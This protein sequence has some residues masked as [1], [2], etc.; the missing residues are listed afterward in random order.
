[1]SS[2]DFPYRSEPFRVIFMKEKGE[3]CEF[4]FTSE[5]YEKYTIFNFIDDR[6]SLNSHSKH[7]AYTE[8][9]SSILWDN[10]KNDATKIV[11]IKD[12][13]YRASEYDRDMI[14]VYSS[15]NLHVLEYNKGNKKG[16]INGLIVDLIKL[17]QSPAGVDLFIENISSYILDEDVLN[18]KLNEI[19]P[20]YFKIVADGQHEEK[21][22]QL[23]KDFFDCYRGISK[24]NRL[25]KVSKFL[26]C[27]RVRGDGDKNVEELKKQIINDF[28]DDQLEKLLETNIE[29]DIKDF[30]REETVDKY[31]RF[32]ADIREVFS[33]PEQRFKVLKVSLKAYSNDEECFRFYWR[34]LC[35]LDYEITIEGV[36]VSEQ[37]QYL[38]NLREYLNKCNVIEGKIRINSALIRMCLVHDTGAKAKFEEI[39]DEIISSGELLQQYLNE[40]TRNIEENGSET[41]KP[42]LLAEHYSLLTNR[43]I[44]I[45]KDVNIIYEEYAQNADNYRDYFEDK[46]VRKI[47]L[48]NEISHKFYVK[49][50]INYLLKLDINTGGKGKDGSKIDYDEV[51]VKIL[52]EPFLWKKVES[53]GFNFENLINNIQFVSGF[54]MDIDT[55]I[56][57]RD[58]VKKVKTYTEV[59]KIIDK[60]IYKH[61]NNN[62][63]FYN[64]CKVYKNIRDIFNEMK[65]DFEESDSLL[66]DIELLDEAYMLKRKLL[67]KENLTLDDF[68]KFSEKRVNISA[69]SHIMYLNKIRRVF[70]SFKNIKKK[71]YQA[72]QAFEILA[73]AFLDGI[74]SDSYKCLLID[75]IDALQPKNIYEY[76]G[77]LTYYILVKT[78]SKKKSIN[79]LN[80]ITH[81]I[82]NYLEQNGM[83]KLMKSYIGY[84]DKELNNYSGSNKEG[85]IR[86]WKRFKY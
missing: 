40:I 76:F 64:D 13:V 12:H 17:G 79:L 56:R 31:Y 32:F 8:L 9:I 81:E 53:N 45:E 38:I 49:D 47:F 84:V 82:T 74:F 58:L 71:E 57:L 75:V 37:I 70:S 34:L 25:E 86:I 6:F 69:E 35:K 15:F 85:L 80:G 7:E 27:L 42:V 19:F 22:I 50:V 41:E 1:M 29:K 3:E 28:L 66:V 78:G 60:Q 72:F 20:E 65:C 11:E 16:N 73:D 2:K 43:K 46:Q 63:F 30:G 51:V 36:D 77:H 24:S 83:I 59:I 4:E 18:S 26:E 44:I 61:F 33:R 67:V 48:K 55:F 54:S 62:L 5:D 52:S 68:K 39:Y 21:K 10:N 23:N 14:D